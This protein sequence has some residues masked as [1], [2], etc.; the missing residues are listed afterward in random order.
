[1]QVNPNAGKQLSNDQ[2]EN[3]PKLVSSYYCEYP[4]IENPS[5]LVSFGTSGHRGSSIR[6]SFNESHLLAI[7]QSIADYRKAEN[8]NGPILI[9]ID[10][11]ALSEPAF[12]TVIEVFV[13]NE[14]EIIIQD[15]GGYTP[16]PVIS[17]A[18]LSYNKTK[19]NNFCD[20]IVITPSHNPPSDGGIKYNLSHGGPAG[21]EIT[22]KLES[23]ANEILKAG[24]KA[25]K[26]IGYSL[27]MRSKF[28]HKRD[29]K[30]PYI[31]DLKNIVD[32]EQVRSSNIKIGV[33]PMGGSGI[34]Y[35]EPLADYYQ[36]NLHLVNKKIDPTFS[37][38]CADKDGKL[39][40]DCSSPYAMAGLIDMGDSFDI[41]FGNDPDYDRHGIVAG[42]DGLM[43]PN[44]YLAIAI[45]YL[46][47]SRTQ[48]S[49][50]LSIGKTL[51]SSSM[52]DRVV[53][54]LNRKLYEVPVGFKW[55]VDG[56]YEGQCAFGGEESAGASFLRYDGSVW[57][58]DKDGIIMDLLAA[59]MTCKTGDNPYVL[60]K[61]LEEK[62]GSPSYERLDA[63][64]NLEQRNTLKNLKADK[65]S[66]DE[67]AGEKV[68]N[69]L[70]KAPGNGESIGGVKVCTENAWFAAR[71]SGTEDIYKIYAESFNGKEHLHTLQNQAQELVQGWL[72]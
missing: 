45:D 63:P 46:I 4:D 23:K 33:D 20:G 71:P 37:F 66:I 55:F 54:G 58:T 7:S 72:K 13:A 5:H 15:G 41:A 64:A 18:I 48:W 3:I 59:E 40:M 39:R 10:T 26:R 21:A 6:N 60:Y 51:V 19:R 38:M 47:Q 28:I 25:V 2:L 16:T 1:M 65:I 27:A 11:H 56:L 30:M 8:I 42:S 50:N 62:F 43:N 12:R 67:F 68:K 36:L 69:V 34:E 14:I 35:W 32:L 61:G 57:S 9:G 53:S 49:E 24:L 52:I 29:F 31:Q 22:S 17:H 44:H 70:V